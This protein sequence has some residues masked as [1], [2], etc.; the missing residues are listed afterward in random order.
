MDEFD[1]RQRVFVSLG[2]NLSVWDRLTDVFVGIPSPMF[3]FMQWIIQSRGV[4]AVDCSMVSKQEGNRLSGSSP[5]PM[6]VAQRE[7]RLL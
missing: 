6:N 5:L 1:D 2:Q 4:V 3:G 7:L